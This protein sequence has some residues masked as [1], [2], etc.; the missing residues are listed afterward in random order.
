MVKGLLLMEWNDRSG[1]EVKVKTPADLDV[2]DK[3]LMQI[4]SAHEYSQDAGLVAI[5]AGASSAISYY[6]GDELDHYLVLFL[7]EGEDPE[8]FEEVVQETAQVVFGNLQVDYLRDIFPQLLV[9]LD[10]YPKASAEQKLAV[11]FQDEFK[12]AVVERLTQDGCAVKEELEIW[13]RD[14]F[15][16]RYFNFSAILASLMRLGLV[17]ITSVKSLLQEMV[18]LTRAVLAFR[19]PPTRI[20]DLLEADGDPSLSP[21]K[22]QYRKQVEGFFKLYRPSLEDSQAVAG[23][24]ADFNSYQILLALRDRWVTRADL[25]KLKRR[26]VEDIDLVLQRLEE[27]DVL[28]KFAQGKNVMDALYLLKSD[29][30]IRPLYPAFMLNTIRQQFVSREQ[31]KEVLLQYL[32]VLQEAYPRKGANA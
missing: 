12:H 31:N 1:L 20:M 4:Y 21:L 18:F 28:V 15:R 32:D 24:L 23:V 8:Q 13:L 11:V 5:A 30:Q 17:K 14:K 22:G 2:S 27:L 26:G 9:R 6:S 16:K 7:K 25:E 19:E 29:P 3:T 10:Q